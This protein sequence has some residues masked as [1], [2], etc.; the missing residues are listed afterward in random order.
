[1]DTKHKEQFMDK[2][3]RL[4]D[5]LNEANE[6]VANVHK[7]IEINSRN[8]KGEKTGGAVFSPNSLTMNE[9]MAKMTEEL[10]KRL[11]PWSMSAT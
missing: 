10:D 2:F 6:Y 5:R 7:F 8:G 3:E 9:I 11:P 4:K 1:L